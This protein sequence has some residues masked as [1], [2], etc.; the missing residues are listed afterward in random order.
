M[1][2]ETFKTRFKKI[3]YKKGQL[4]E[5]FIWIKRLS[6]Y[7]KNDSHKAAILKAI[8]KKNKLADEFNILLDGKTY[9]EWKE[10]SL[11]IS[12]HSIKINKTIIQ[13]ELYREKFIKLQ[14]EFISLLEF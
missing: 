8:D 5:S 12:S 3:V 4:S 1:E 2:L 10:R 11:L 6:N 13:L 14:N 7:D 9:E